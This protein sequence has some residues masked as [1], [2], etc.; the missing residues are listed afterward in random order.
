[1][2]KFNDFN[3]VTLSP[4]RLPLLGHNADGWLF[5]WPLATHFWSLNVPMTRRTMSYKAEFN[6]ACTRCCEVMVLFCRFRP[7]IF[8]DD[9]IF[10]TAARHHLSNSRDLVRRIQGE[11][12]GSYQTL[13]RFVLLKKQR[14]YL[15]VPSGPMR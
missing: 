15:Y 9:V 13:V 10:L 3:R 1:M 7:N 11:W 8:T 4:G 5:G 2:A 6:Q 12:H 14:E